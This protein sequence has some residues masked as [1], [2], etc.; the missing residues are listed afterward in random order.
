MP[1]QEHDGNGTDSHGKG[2]HGKG[3][4]TGALGKGTYK[5]ALG[6]GTGAHGKGKDTGARGQGKDTGARGKGKDAGGRGKGKGKG[7]ELIPTSLAIVQLI[8]GAWTIERFIS[9]VELRMDAWDYIDSITGF[10]V[11]DSPSRS[12]SRSP[13]AFDRPSRRD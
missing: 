3:N 9:V 8:D 2:D 1:S 6:K 7:K 12:R 11:G 5:G 4:D 13:C 10:S